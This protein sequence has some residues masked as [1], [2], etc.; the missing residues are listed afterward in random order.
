MVHV[1]IVA[2]VDPRWLKFEITESSLMKEP[3]EL[4]GTL[5]TL[6][7]L[8][9]P[10]LIDDF[11][12]GFSSL[13]Y[14]DRL[15]VDALKIEQALVRNLEGERAKTPI[16][17]AV[18]DLAKRLRVT[19]VAEGVETAAQA[20]LLRNRGCDFAQGYFYSKLV[21]ARPCLKMLQ[22][23]KRERPLTEQVARTRDRGRLALRQAHIL[24]IGDQLLQPRQGGL[25]VAYLL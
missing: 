23:L 19:T 8:G 1:N 21:A 18:L 20:Q 16:I 25:R 24:Q 12:T 10:V 15:P 2:E 4:I 11:G 9:S 7:T 3:D 22:E 5:Q 6:R 14:L 17:D 13:R